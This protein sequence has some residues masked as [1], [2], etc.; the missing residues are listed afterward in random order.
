[1]D[2]AIPIEHEFTADAGYPAR[3][4]RALFRFAVTRPITVVLL[5]LIALIT[6]LGAVVVV[7]SLDSVP[8]AAASGLLIGILLDVL[9]L[10]LAYLRTQRRVATIAPAGATYAIGFGET[11]VR[12][13]SPLSNAEVAYRAFQSVTRRGEFVFLHHRGAR[14][15][16]A[17]PGALFVGAAYE[18]LRASVE[19][20]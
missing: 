9:V 18:R 12:I 17:L 11:S 10:V 16:T 7:N 6:M 15:Y 5:V 3:L 14:L 20:A 4:T 2:T 1:M 13:V 19:S 8:Q